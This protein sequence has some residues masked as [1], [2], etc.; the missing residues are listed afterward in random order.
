M[1]AA[2]NESSGAASPV[3]VTKPVALA[4]LP[5]TA[6]YGPQPLQPLWPPW[7]SSVSP[8]F[9]HTPTPIDI[10]LSYAS[11]P[12]EAAGNA[13]SYSVVVVSSSRVIDASVPPGPLSLTITTSPSS[14]NP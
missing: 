7:P 12:S 13:N 8:S 9:T 2:L 10:P 14:L 4:V 1:S 11:N 5:Y 3:K 6:A